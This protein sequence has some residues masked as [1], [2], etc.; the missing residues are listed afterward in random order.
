MVTVALSRELGTFPVP[1]NTEAT[2]DN[3]P[4]FATAFPLIGMGQRYLTLARLRK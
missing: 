2:T 4:I 3:G 1:D